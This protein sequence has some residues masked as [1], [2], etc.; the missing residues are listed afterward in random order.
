MLDTLQEGCT[1][2]GRLRNTAR[3][4]SL[5]LHFQGSTAQN[6]TVWACFTLYPSSSSPFQFYC[7]VAPYYSIDAGAARCTWE[8]HVHSYLA[9][10]T[11]R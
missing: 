11:G 4:Q 8:G 5:F 7:K 3:R 2:P 1:G 10:K 6:R 9:Q